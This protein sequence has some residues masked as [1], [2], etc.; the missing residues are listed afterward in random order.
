MRLAQS[1]TISFSSQILKFSAFTGAEFFICVFI[2]QKLVSLPI[3]FGLY[4]P[5]HLPQRFIIKSIQSRQICLENGG[6]FIQ[7]GG[8]PTSRA[9]RS[10]A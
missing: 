5:S 4:P 2:Q 10:T 1:K 6:G 9:R 3:Q 7:P 8:L